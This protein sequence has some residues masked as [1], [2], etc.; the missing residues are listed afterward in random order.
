MQI[1]CSVCR[2]PS[3]QRELGGRL[4]TGGGSG[5]SH[6]ADCRRDRW[7]WRSGDGQAWLIPES[8]SVLPCPS[9]GC[10]PA[11]AAAL[12]AF[13]DRGWLQGWV[14]RGPGRS[15]RACAACPA[16]TACLAQRRP[17]LTLCSGT[18]RALALCVPMA[19]S[20]WRTWW[21]WHATEPS[22]GC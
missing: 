15:H 3:A 6:H 13:G 10:L 9:P 17:N 1:P 22:F 2:L 11:R 12:Q 14:R 5:A 18:P 7:G 4:P 19:P 21:L 8:V 20:A 16:V